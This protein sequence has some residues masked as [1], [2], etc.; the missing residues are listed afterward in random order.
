MNL[1]QN[2]QI[3]NKFNKSKFESNGLYSQLFYS[4]TQLESDEEQHPGKIHW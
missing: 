2:I 1:N 4:D 3:Y